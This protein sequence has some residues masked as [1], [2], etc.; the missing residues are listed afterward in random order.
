METIPHRARRPL[1]IALIGSTYPRSQEDYEVPWLRES[2]NRIAHRGHQITVIAPS[3]S[4]LQNHQIDG[5]EVRRF[6]YAPARWEKLT[7][8][9]GAPNKLKKG[10]DRLALEL[11]PTVDILRALRDDGSANGVFMVGFAAETEHVIDNARAKLDAK[12]LDLVVVNDV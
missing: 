11:V 5:I 2:V 6:R 3:Y 8:G 7:H 12:Q 4:G 9:D 1:R 10:A